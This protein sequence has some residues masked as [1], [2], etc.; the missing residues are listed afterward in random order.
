MLD[1]PDKEDN[2]FRKV[3]SKLDNETLKDISTKKEE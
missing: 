2:K 3:L 1:F